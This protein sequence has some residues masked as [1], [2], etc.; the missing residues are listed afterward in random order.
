MHGT[1]VLRF[2]FWRSRYSSETKRPVRNPRKGGR[3]WPPGTCVPRIVQR[4][5]RKFRRY[6]PCGSNVHGDFQRP[7]DSIKQFAIDGSLTVFPRKTESVSGKIPRGGIRCRS[8]P[9]D[10]SNES[11]SR[12]RDDPRI[13]LRGYRRIVAG[14]PILLGLI[15]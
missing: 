5:N 6:V 10:R 11:L 8:G 9:P 15:K 4:V 12:P 3:S 2:N 7:V 13:T 14:N 1:A